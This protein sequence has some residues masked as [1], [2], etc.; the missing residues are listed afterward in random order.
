MI[1]I[2]NVEVF[3]EEQEITREDLDNLLFL[4]TAIEGS[5][6]MNR[7][8]GLDSEVLGESL[9]EAKNLYIVNVIK[10]VNNYNPNFEVEDITFEEDIKNGKLKPQVVISY[11]E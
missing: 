1:D 5:I 3:I 7:S 10:K 6:P 11:N 4:F 8:A 2:E 9:E